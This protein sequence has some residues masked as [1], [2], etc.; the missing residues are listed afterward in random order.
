MG[1]LR[2]WS[3]VKSTVANSNEGTPRGQR[4]DPTLPSPIP[5]NISSPSILSLGGN[6][7]RGKKSASPLFSPKPVG[8]SSGASSYKA[9]DQL[10]GL[11][12][13]SNEKLAPFRS[14][15]QDI[16]VNNDMHSED[17]DI[18]AEENPENYEGKAHEKKGPKRPVALANLD[19]QPLSV[20][21]DSGLFSE[22]SFQLGGFCITRKGIRESPDSIQ[23]HNSSGSSLEGIP[24]DTDQSLQ[25][26][27]LDDIIFI[28]V[29][30]AGASGRVIL[31]EHVSSKTKL[32]VKVVNVYDEAKRTQ[33]VKELRTLSSYTSRFLVHFYGA[34]YDGKGAVHIALE[35]MDG[36]ALS[37][38]IQEYGPVPESIANTIAYHSLLGLKFL[39]GSKLLHRDF[40]P[41]N[42]LL[43]RELRRAKLSDF[44]LSRD[45]N[46][47]VM[48][49][50]ETFVGTTAY[51]SPERLNGTMY[52]YESDIWGL[53]VSIA[54]CILGKYPWEKPQVFFDFYME[55]A[56][57]E[58]V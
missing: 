15:S 13:S 20:G 51:M 27:S 57:S 31:A 54:E 42:I 33:L 9:S 45:L 2:L 7:A 46:T 11:E 50:V 53:G 48:S 1:K 19:Q 18:Q 4:N 16:M 47:E 40:K 38:V 35:Y 22:D 41:A 26:D 24:T 25:I 36:G 14:I 3:R 12:R 17:Y 37:S 43:S 34:F 28:K 49:K 5:H 6:K 58:Q 29:L 23:R 10:L 52:T 8:Q 30:G 39:H 55:A 32:A 44:G 56:K 21:R